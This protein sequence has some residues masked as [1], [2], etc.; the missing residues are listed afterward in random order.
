MYIPKLDLKSFEYLPEE[1]KCNCLRAL[2]ESLV[3][4][5]REYLSTFPNTPKL[6]EHNPAYVFKKRPFSLDTW[7]DI[8]RTIELATGDCK[9]FA[10]WRVAELRQQG[11]T[12]VSPY[13]KVNRIPN[14][15]TG[16]VFTI[17]HIQVR[18]GLQI[19]DPS[20]LLGMPT[21]RVPFN[22]IRG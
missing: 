9:D 8:P 7:Q 17:Y 1:R 10:C 13:I 12:D 11:Y 4:I 2:L 3:A 15:Q 14:P 6:Y 22:L 21:G 20:L 5:N 16:E 18:I 19:E